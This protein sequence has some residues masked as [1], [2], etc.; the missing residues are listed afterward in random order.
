MRKSKKVMGPYRY[1]SPDP[2]ARK[3]NKNKITGLSK[4]DVSIFELKYTILFMLKFNFLWR[5]TLTRIQI[6]L[7]LKAGTE[8]AL[9]PVRIRDTVSVN[10]ENL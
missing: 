7:R 6:A 2:G 3:L 1:V 8:S 9:K 4:S 10:S 5:Q